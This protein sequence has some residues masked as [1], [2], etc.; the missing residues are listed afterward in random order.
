M[1][2]IL[3]HINGVVR[4]A[5]R[6]Y[7]SAERALTGAL[8]AGDIA[9][10]DAAREDVV[11]AGRQSVDLLHHLADFV[12]EEPSSAPTPFANL[13]AV[14]AAVDAHCTFLRNG[15]YVDDVD[16]LRD[17]AV[18]FKHH[19]P[20]SGRIA[21]SSDIAPVGIGFGV[22]R[23]GE[24]KYGGVEQ[25]AIS[26]TGDT[27]ALSSVLQNVFDAWMILIGQPLPPIS[28]Y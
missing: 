6:K 12:L 26:T 19:R 15:K 4:P 28:Q 18:A 5:L 1:Q 23:Y 14:R 9:A 2:P 22:C 11:L 21:V 8:E 25:I 27:R 20:K 13:A 24:G 17:T 7:I 10:I 3:D 16:L